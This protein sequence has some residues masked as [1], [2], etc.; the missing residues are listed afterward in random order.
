MELNLINLINPLLTIGLRVSGLVLFAPL[1]GSAAIPARIKAVLVIALTAVLYPALA[2]RVG[3]VMVTQWPLV[4]I[5]ELVVGVSLGIAANLLFDA[6][7]MAGQVLSIQMGYSLV[8]ILDPQTQAESTVVALFH[9]TIAMLIFLGLNVHHALLRVV[10]SSFD[11]LPVGA[12]EFSPQFAL[13]TL[14]IGGTVLAL[15]IRIAAP[16]LA[17]TLVADLAIGLLGKAS[18]QMPLILLGPAIKSMLG[19][20]VLVGVMKYWPSLLE[21]WFLNSLTCA[22]HLLHLAR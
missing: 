15:G 1:F 4:V 9:Q 6:M 21:R 14:K 22:E 12:A 19:I 5:H 7:Q 2:S 13:A 20:G 8:S 18:P 11:Y 3:G 10:A 16:V 17:A